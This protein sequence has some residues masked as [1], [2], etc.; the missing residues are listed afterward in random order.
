[1][2]PLLGVS[3][4]EQTTVH[5]HCRDVADISSPPLCDQHGHSRS[6]SLKA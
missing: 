6:S 2:F 5:R 3:V 4:R 1:M